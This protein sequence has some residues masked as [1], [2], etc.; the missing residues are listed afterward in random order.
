MQSGFSSFAKKGEWGLEYMKCE[1]LANVKGLELCNECQVTLK[2]RGRASA[3]ER[4]TG[5]PLRW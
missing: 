1:L 2:R 3:S 4:G 5:M